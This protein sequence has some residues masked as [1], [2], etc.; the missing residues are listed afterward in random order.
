M[1]LSLSSASSGYCGDIASIDAEISSTKFLSGAPSKRIFL[2]VRLIMR[3]STYPLPSLPGV[4]PSPINI[5][6]VRAWS[7]TTRN[8]ISFSG[9]LPYLMPE[10]SEAFRR[11]IAVVSIS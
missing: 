9:D 10:I 11:I 6:A 5:V 4:T 1:I 7:A 8:E 3:R 2:I